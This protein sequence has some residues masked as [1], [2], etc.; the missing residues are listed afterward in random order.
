MED[1]ETEDAEMPTLRVVTGEPSIAT[2]VA[3]RIC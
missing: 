2:L 3:R 1:E